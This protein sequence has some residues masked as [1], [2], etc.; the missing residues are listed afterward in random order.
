[1]IDSALVAEQLANLPR[2][3]S[4]REAGLAAAIAS[5]RRTDVLPVAAARPKGQG[6]LDFDAAQSRQRPVRPASRLSETAWPGDARCAARGPRSAQEQTGR[7]A[8]ER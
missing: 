6:T 5:S 1:V 4:A 7:T 8:P 3:K 2:P